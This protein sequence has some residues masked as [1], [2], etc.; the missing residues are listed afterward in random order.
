VKNVLSDRIVEIP[1]DASYLFRLPVQLEPAGD[2]EILDFRNLSAPEEL[3]KIIEI[4]AFARSRG[5]TGKRFHVRGVS[6]TESVAAIRETFGTLGYFQSSLNRYE[7]PLATAFVTFSSELSDTGFGQ[8]RA[9]RGTFAA[10]S[11]RS[12]LNS[13]ILSG[14]CL[15]ANILSNGEKIRNEAETL[16][17]MLSEGVCS[18]LLLGK[19]CYYHF[20]QI[21]AAS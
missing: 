18:P 11:V 19:I 13:G 12:A 1:G 10:K 8:S 20:A 14:L 2:L 4:L 6:L 9:R 16:A 3:S 15:N 17:R 21:G 5:T 7:L